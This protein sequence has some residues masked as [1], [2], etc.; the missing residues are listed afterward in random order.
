MCSFLVDASPSMDFGEPSKFFFAK[1]I[2]SALGFVGM[3]R[4]T[5]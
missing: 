2:A 4:A 1:Q 5:A 3:C